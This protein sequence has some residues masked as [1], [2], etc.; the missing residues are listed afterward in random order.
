M[1]IGIDASNIVTGGGVTHLKEILSSFDREEFIDFESIIV[2]SSLK[3]LNLIENNDLIEKISFSELNSNLLSRVYFQYFKYDKEIKKRCDILLSITGDY[4]GGFKPLIG[5]SRNMLLFERDIWFH[6]NSP[7]EILRFWLNYKK[8]KKCFKNSLGIIFISNYA[9]NYISN[10]LSLKEK[11]KKIIHHGISSRFF[12]KI[13]KQKKITD[14]SFENPFKFLYVSTVHVYKHQWNVVEA[15]SKLRENGYPV[16]LDLVGGVIFKSSGKKLFNMINK[17]DKNKEFIFF[18]G[19]VDY[20]V[21][22]SFY[23]NS[24]G[25]IYASTCENMPNILL[26]SMSSGTPIACSNKQPMPEFLKD[27]GFYFDAKSTDSIF[28][29]LL[30]FLLSPEERYIN[31]Q[32]SHQN[33]LSYNWKKTSLETFN[34][35]KNILRYAKK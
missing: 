23:K 6:I 14:Y 22:E 12:S 30:S 29:T 1:R 19:N 32:K 35:I 21:I 24:D 33:I 7:K 15:I 34:F 8:Q 2:F 11:Q 17:V 16:T 25:I 27:G 28:N 26:E 9:K 18:N 13:K 10:K 5:I 4:I 31:A 3:T 20:D